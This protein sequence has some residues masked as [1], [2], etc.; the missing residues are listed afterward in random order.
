MESQFRHTME[1]HDGGS[2]LQSTVGAKLGFESNPKWPLIEYRSK[3]EFNLHTADQHD[4][5]AMDTR[6]E[7]AEREPL[8]TVLQRANVVSGHGL[9]NPQNQ[10]EQVHQSGPQNGESSSGFIDYR[11]VRLGRCNL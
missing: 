9:G 3:S 6:P 1:A 5:K 7:L 4:A 2:Q 8:P 11:Y 10:W